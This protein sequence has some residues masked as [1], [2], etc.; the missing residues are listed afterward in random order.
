MSFTF[1]EVGA[2]GEGKSEFVKDMIRGARS[3]VFDVN[4]EYGSRTKYKGQ[5]PLMLSDNPNAERARYRPKMMY[6]R[7]DANAFM[8]MCRQKR[9]TQCVF[10]EATVY[11]EGRQQELAKTL[12]VNRIHTGNV[13]HFIFHS[14]RS[15]PPR[16]M[17]MANY[18]V[19]HRTL[20]EDYIVQDKYPRLWQAFIELQPMPKGSRKIIQLMKQ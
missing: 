3:F 13:Y 20:D 9:D 12:I 6:L 11:L 2:P 8:L 17:E 15:I 16:I 10:E 1:I 4:D 18:V 5:Q 7:D 14:I 19:L